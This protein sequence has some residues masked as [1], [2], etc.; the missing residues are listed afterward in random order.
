MGKEVGFGF[1]I[2]TIFPTSQAAPEPAGATPGIDLSA[3]S[4]Q[5][6]RL[7]RGDERLLAARATIPGANVPGDGSLPPYRS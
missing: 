7:L 2:L 6:H 3:D 4:D 5:H 1:D